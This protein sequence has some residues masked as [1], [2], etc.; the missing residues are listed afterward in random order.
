MRNTTLHKILFIGDLILFSMGAPDATD[1]LDPE[2][3]TRP[4]L[5][6]MPP[7]HHG[8]PHLEI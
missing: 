2:D 5:N 8:P 4:P 6:E 3:G 7:G 1:S